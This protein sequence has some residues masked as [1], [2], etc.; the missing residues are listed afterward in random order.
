MGIVNLRGRIMAVVDSKRL[1]GIGTH[2]AT[3]KVLVMVAQVGEHLVGFTVDEVV[4]VARIADDAVE[5]VGDLVAPE[6]AQRL[7][8]VLKLDGQLV[9]LLNAERLLDTETLGGFA[10]G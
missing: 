10:N 9:L 5:P 2:D 4:Q 6:E 8:G 1:L 7:E 3:D